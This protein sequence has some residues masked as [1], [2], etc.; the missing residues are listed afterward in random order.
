MRIL[1]VDDEKIKR[2]TL[3]DDLATQGHEVETA[4]DGRDALGKLSAARF[5]VVVTDLKMPNIDGIELLKRIKQGPLADTVVVMMTAYGSIEVAVEAVKLGAFDFVTKPFRNDDI[6][7]LLA[8]IERERKQA[9]EAAA[10][11]EPPRPDASIAESIVTES[12]SMDRVMRMIEIAARTDANVLLLGETG[13]GKDLIASVIHRHSYRSGFPYVKVGCTLFPPQLIESE[14]YG[15]EKGSFTGAE[16]KRKGRFDLAQGGTLYLDD[17]D[18]IPLE[19]QSK[20]LRAIEEKVFERVGGTTPI[21][22]DVRI[23]A[24]T[25]QNLLDK[26]DDGSFRRDLY[27]RLDVLRINIPPLR[28]RL[29]DLPILVDHL[30]QR[31]AKDEPY[32]IDSDAVDVLLRHDWPGNIRELYHT[33]ERAWLVGADH[34][35]ARLLSAEMAGIAAKKKPASG[36]FRAAM[37]QAERQLLADALAAAGGNKSA[38]AEALGMKASTFRDKLAKHGLG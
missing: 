1:V 16:E 22:A 38:A 33:L 31:I 11:D 10:A 25:K 7:P 18:D 20:L 36:G 2:V 24:S 26:I 35:T 19:H 8:R 15:H 17:V 32:V 28:D 12:P 3:A 30:M 29:D 23:I 5:D 27:Y 34:I 21:Q 9:A 37:D 13:V 6:F 14:L 4:C